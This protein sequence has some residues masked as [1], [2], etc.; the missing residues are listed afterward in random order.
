M[1]E[2]TQS[3]WVEPVGNHPCDIG[4]SGPALLLKIDGDRCDV[5]PEKLGV[6]LSVPRDG[7][8]EIPE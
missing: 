1:T 4:Y 8:L 7:V 6:V 5:L 3:V 2:S